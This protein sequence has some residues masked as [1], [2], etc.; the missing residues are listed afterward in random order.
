[1]TSPD[2]LRAPALAS[3]WFAR[4]ESSAA[5]VVVTGA[6]DVLHVGH[7]RFLTEVRERRPDLPVVVGVEDDERV[8]GWKGPSRPVNTADERAEV[9]A[10]LPCVDCVFIIN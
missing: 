7:V 4:P 3:R 6:F 2:P 5:P 10:A 1:M 8:R 9:L